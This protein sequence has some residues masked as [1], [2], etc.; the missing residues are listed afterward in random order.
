[1]TST[2]S[3]AQIQKTDTKGRVRTTHERRAELLAEYDKSGLSAMRF[4]QVTGLNYQT[5]IGWVQDRRKRQA[6]R[7]ARKTYFKNLKQ[8]V[9]SAATAGQGAAAAPPSS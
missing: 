9:Y 4:A 1:M 2:E 5:F 8:P 3:G 7:I 6:L